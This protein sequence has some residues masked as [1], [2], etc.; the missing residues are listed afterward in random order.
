MLSNSHVTKNILHSLA[1]LQENFSGWEAGEK[2]LW[3]ILAAYYKNPSDQGALDT[4]YQLGSLRVYRNTGQ[5]EVSLLTDILLEL[6]AGIKVLEWPSTLGPRVPLEIIDLRDWDSPDIDKD[7]NL[8]GEYYR[9]KAYVNGNWTG[10]NHHFTHGTCDRFV[11]EDCEIRGHE[12]WG[13][14]AYRM[15]YANCINHCRFGDIMY[16][17][18]LYWN[19]A[20]YNNDPDLDLN[21]PSLII[22]NCIFGDIASQAIQ[23]VQRASEQGFDF[24]AAGDLTRGGDVVIKNS[25]FR[26]IGWN[27]GGN[28]RASYGISAFASNNHVLVENCHL[29]NSCQKFSKGAIMSSWHPSTTVK[30]SSFMLG[31]GDRPIAEFEGNNLLSIKDSTFINEGPQKFI[32]IKSCQNIDISDCSGNVSIQVDGNIVGPIT[33]GYQQRE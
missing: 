7:S 8:N 17:H 20:G 4:A 31:I 27:H 24:E 18:G 19:L 2:V 9:G 32:R 5:K 10:F 11:L 21:V 1:I 28:A 30:D 22:E 33:N 3:Q 16:E 14:R 6:W 29:D 15:R 25:F 26:N 13:T 23:L 12:K